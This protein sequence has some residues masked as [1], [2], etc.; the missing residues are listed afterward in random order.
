M[1]NEDLFRATLQ[2][3][4]NEGNEK[5]KFAL[6]LASN[7]VDSSQAKS[8]ATAELKRANSNLLDALSY[9]DSSWSRSTDRSIAS[10][11]TNILNAVS[12]LC[13]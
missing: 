13:Q 9:N 3:L 2:E 5:A 7:S 12:L 6:S 4:A 8:Q 1:T 10:A 11:Q